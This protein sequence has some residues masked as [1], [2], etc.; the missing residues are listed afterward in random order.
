MQQEK[1]MHH[2]A[3]LSRVLGVS[4]SGYYAWC[5]RPV[6]THAQIDQILLAQI[7]DI[8]EQ[9]RGI[10]GAPRIHAELHAQGVRCGRKRVAT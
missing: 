1:A 10:Y 2:I 7:R 9:S 5:D 4:P 3:T 8:H 6:S